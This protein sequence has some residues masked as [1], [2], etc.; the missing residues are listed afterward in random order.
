MRPYPLAHSRNKLTRAAALSSALLD[1]RRRGGLGRC[2]PVSCGV[3]RSYRER[4][5][6]RSATISDPRGFSIKCVLLIYLI[7]GGRGQS[8]N[9]HAGCARRPASGES[10]SCRGRQRADS[11]WDC[12]AIGTGCGTRS[13][14]RIV[15]PADRCVGV[16]QHARVLH[17]RPREVPQCVPRLSSRL[18]AKV[19]VLTGA[20]ADFIHTQKRNPQVSPRCV[21]VARMADAP[22]GAD[23]PQGQKRT[24]PPPQLQLK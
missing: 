20:S 22:L 12:G 5:L 11:D 17:P 9:M 18:I 6:T 16:E 2:S 24:S 10:R 4:A 1:R 19:R 15:S 13:S 21:V 8:T 3:P 23:A 14:S 7:I